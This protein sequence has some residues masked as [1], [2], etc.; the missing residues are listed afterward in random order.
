MFSRQLFLQQQRCLLPIRDRKYLSMQK[1]FNWLI[2]FAL[3]FATLSLFPSNEVFARPS[4]QTS[5]TTPNQLI[6]AV[7]SLRISYGLLPLAEHSILMQ[8][9]QSQ[10]DYMAATGQTTHA[11]PG[12]ISYTQQLLTLGFPL[13]GDLSLGGFRAENILSNSSPLVWDGVPPAW[14][15][16]DHMNTMLSQNFTHIGA[17]ISQGTGGYYYAV[18]CAATTGSG[19]MQSSASTILTSVPVSENGNSAGISQ[20]MVPVVLN[21]A[22]PSGDVFHKVQ[23]GQSLWSVAIEYGTTIKN[24]QALNNLGEDLVVYQGQ[25]LLVKKAATQPVPTPLPPATPIVIIITPATPSISFPTALAA[26]STATPVET[27]EESPAS[28]PSSSKLLIGLLIIAAFVGGGVAVWLI[29]DPN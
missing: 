2:A 18:D 16:A 29:R 10:A 9:A 19:Q 14:Q 4:A 23:Y 20:Y 15:D 3:L 24:I 11:R 8:S 6:N 26:T 5:I 12:G 17:G 25:E 27:E 28:K 22:L 1:T 7:N 13:S 21:T